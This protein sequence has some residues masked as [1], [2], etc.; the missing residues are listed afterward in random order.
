M[1]IDKE[2]LLDRPI[3]C[4]RKWATLRLAG[5]VSG[6]VCLTLRVLSFAGMPGS[7]NPAFYRPPRGC[8][9]VETR[10]L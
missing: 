6:S 5:N 1:V 10:L 7:N 2:V 9:A 8:H 4:V 3:I